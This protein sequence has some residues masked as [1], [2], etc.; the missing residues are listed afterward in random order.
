MRIAANVSAE[1]ILAVKLM[2]L[3]LKNI[4]MKAVF[5][6]V[7]ERKTCLSLSNLGA[8]KLPEVMA[9][10]VQRLDFILGVQATAPYNCGIVSYKD[11]LCISFIRNTR[12]PQLES[13]FFRVMQELGLS[14]E[15]RS[16]GGQ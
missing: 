14:A 3:F 12:E 8:V 10:H 13:A 4:I 5:K 11:K 15:V 16:N 7:G 6:A 1:K 2:P 9:E